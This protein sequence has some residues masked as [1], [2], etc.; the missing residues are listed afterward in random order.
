MAKP[1]EVEL[2]AKKWKFQ[3]L[4]SSLCAILGVVL[5]IV[6][7]GLSGPGGG[8]QNQTLLKLGGLLLGGGLVW[9]LFAR[10]MAWWNHG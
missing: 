7:V 5:M 10:I 1:T 3:I 9:F 4:L 6:A 8:G 2:T